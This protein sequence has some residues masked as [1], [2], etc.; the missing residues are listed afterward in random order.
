MQKYFYGGMTIK[1]LKTSS[2]LLLFLFVA[3]SVAQDTPFF[4]TNSKFKPTTAIEL[5]D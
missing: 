4:D 2:I 3:P 5:C 1:L